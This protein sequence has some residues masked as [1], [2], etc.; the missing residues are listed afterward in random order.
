V[1]TN[2]RA[3]ERNAAAAVAIYVRVSTEEQRE[4]QSIATQKDFAQRYC[5]LHGLLTFRVYEDNGVSGTVSIENRPDGRKILAD[6]REGR[7]DQ[8]L[9]YKLDRLGRDTRMILNTVDALEQIGVRVRSM[10][11]EFDTGTA[12]GRLMLTLLSG[13]AAHEREMIRERSIAG[14]RRLAHA[15]AWLG[16]IVPFGYRKE[17]EKQEARLVIADACLEEVGMS[18]ADVVRQIYH[19]AAEERLSCRAIAEHLTATG[20]P[21]VYARDDR[22]LLRGKRQERTAGIWRASRVRNLIANSVYR[23]QHIYGKRSRSR[24]KSLITRSAP[25]IVS[26]ELWN[27]AQQA[28]SDHFLFGR[29]NAKNRYLLRGLMK[30]QQCALTFVGTCNTRPSGKVDFY[31]RCTGKHNAR[32]LFRVGARRCS[33]KDVNGEQ[34]ESL[35]WNDVARFLADPGEV[36]ELLAS[37]LSSES[38]EAPVTSKTTQQIEMALNQK[39]VEKDRILALYRRG[40][41][42]EKALERQLREIETEE[43]ALRQ[44]LEE[45]AEMR[46]AADSAK[47]ETLEADDLL[48]RLRARLEQ[49]I[50]WE[51]KREL[52]TILV[53]VAEI[54]TIETEK[55]REAIVNV[56]YLF[57]PF[58]SDRTDTDSSLRPA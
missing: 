8:L 25:A 16:G 20:I 28:L 32:Q 14:T 4:R 52:I 34:L 7:F 11:E 24:D 19:M 9:I 37:K 33:S 6:A 57:N 55:G 56:R 44:E 38:P 2:P 31:Y 46:R 47:L 45:A 12:S 54:E 43:K 40:R 49:G 51:L 36:L 41:I 5:E 3:S 18:E 21:C 30:C 10:T 15:G 50:S 48:R 42:D 39:Q 58:N 35:V 27:R 17:G 23:G 26:E 29:R 22:L 1:S 13:F 53:D